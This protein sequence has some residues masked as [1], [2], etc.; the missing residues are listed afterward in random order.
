MDRDPNH[1]FR[2][3]DTLILSALA[4][5]YCA[6][7]YPLL[8]WGDEPELLTAAW[9]EGVPH[10]TGYPLYL[11]LSE[12][13]L[14]IPLGS[15]AWRGHFFSAVSALIGIGFLLRLDPSRSQD[16]WRSIGWRIGIV[17]FALSGWVWEPSLIAEVYTLS[18][19][20]FGATLMASAVFLAQPSAKGLCS[21]GLLAGLAVGHHRI[22]SLM[23]PGL[24]LWLLSG[25]RRLPSRSRALFTAVAVFLFA[26]VLPYTLLYSRA[27]GNPP[28]NWENPSTLENLWKVFSATQFRT[29]QTLIR[30]NRSVSHESGQGPHPLMASGERVL[31]LARSLWREWGPLLAFAPVG[32]LAALR[33]NPLS[34]LAG[35]LAWLP[36]VVFFAQYHVGDSRAFH[37]F[38]CLPAA[39]ALAW[40]MGMALEWVGDRRRLLGWLSVFALVLWPGYQWVRFPRPTGS[41][42][43]LP[44]RFARRTLDQLPPNA[45]LLVIPEHFGAP[46]DYVYFPLAYEHEVAR[47]A[48]SVAVLAEGFFTA[49]WYAST[50]EREG[51]RPRVIEA[52]LQGTDSVRVRDLSWKE[53]AEEQRASRGRRKSG[54]PGI[55][56]VEGRAYFEDWRA[57]ARILAETFLPEL[58]DRTLFTTA[59]FPLLDPL[60][61]GGIEW[62]RVLDIP[63]PTESFAPLDGM[64]L[65]SGRLYHVRYDPSKVKAHGR[66]P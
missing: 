44:S 6:S 37:I 38:P 7:I 13:F 41:V 63:L 36:V 47:R 64:P 55:L 52:S 14:R 39:L 22:L 8:W 25:V 21:I 10:P 34:A 35:L 59:A 51:I 29:D 12:I 9:R 62:E 57:G 66:N 50:L 61:P 4:L 3:V 27:H 20:L 33:W 24:A 19:G 31:E 56:R 40:G 53:F 45:V 58:G 15:I 54:P 28:L 23:L 2:H 17:S 46:I 1:A 26:V 11:A 60:V 30:I 18:L 65:P 32:F 43:E 42:A 49:P 5:V 48:R 16:F